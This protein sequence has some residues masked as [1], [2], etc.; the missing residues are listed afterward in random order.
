MKY[1]IETW[2]NKELPKK[3]GHGSK[4]EWKKVGKGDVYIGLEKVTHLPDKWHKKEWIED[5]WLMIAI[6]KPNGRVKI[7]HEY[8]LE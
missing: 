7:I 8:E 2:W 1:E 5:Y 6:K 4:M 3:G